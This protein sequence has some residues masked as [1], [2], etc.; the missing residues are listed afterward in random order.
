M[1]RVLCADN[2]EAPLPRTPKEAQ[3]WFYSG[4]NPASFIAPSTRMEERLS[5]QVS[6]GKARLL[7][8]TQHLIA[9]MGLGLNVGGFDPTLPKDEEYRLGDTDASGKITVYFSDAFWSAYFAKVNIAYN[10]DTYASYL[11]YIL[12][13][14]GAE[15]DYSRYYDAEHL[16]WVVQGDAEGLSD[17][18]RVLR[19]TLE[20]PNTS[21]H[22]FDGPVYQPDEDFRRSLAPDGNQAH[23]LQA[24]IRYGLGI[25]SQ[26]AAD[27][28]ALSHYEKVVGEA[29]TAQ[30]ERRVKQRERIQAWEFGRAKAAMTLAERM[31][32]RTSLT[33]ASSILAE[34]A[35]GQNR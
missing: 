30:I 32:F 8:G 13:R 22:S 10:H 28:Y 31:A 6:Q 16:A 9:R 25:L 26:R 17:S 20:F 14:A 27:L 4:D 12:L 29:P 23:A 7:E 5:D 34:N 35:V 1:P 24:L 21:W 18:L 3:Q 2:F 33:H 19:R 11:V 15:G